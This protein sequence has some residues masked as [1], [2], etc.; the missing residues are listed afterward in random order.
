MSAAGGVRGQSGQL[1]QA[2]PAS[3]A[4]GAWLCEGCVTGEQQRERE[5][6]T[7]CVGEEV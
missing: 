2:L 6:R 1:A 3:W 7:V 4:P 5:N